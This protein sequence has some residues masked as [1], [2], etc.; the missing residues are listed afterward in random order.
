MK[1]GQRLFL[2]NSG[3]SF[4]SAENKKGLVLRPALEHNKLQLKLTLFAHFLTKKISECNSGRLLLAHVLSV[5]FALLAIFKR[6][7]AQADAAFCWINIGNL[8]FNFIAD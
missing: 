5:L 8:R 1:A 3:P 6:A 7:E 4:V 2:V